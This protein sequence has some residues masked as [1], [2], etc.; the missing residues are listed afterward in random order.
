MNKKAA[1]ALRFVLGGYLA[2]VGV[3]L[4]IQMVRE[5]PTNMILMCA[6]S[7]V[8]VIVGGGYAIYSLKKLLDIRKEERGTVVSDEPEEDSGSAAVNPNAVR[9]MNMQSTK[10]KKVQ[11]D[12][13]EKGSA[14]EAGG[15]ENGSAGGEEPAASEEPA[16]G[17]TPAGKDDKESQE[18]SERG[19][20]MNQE[21]IEEEIENDY[22][23]K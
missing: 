14:E 19:E 17:K 18:E 12:S 1:F 6:L 2:F 15:N 21:T 16:A 11:E 5:K 23:E 8:F 10:I 9:Q 4:I 7:V 22:E 3:R 20:G 13:A